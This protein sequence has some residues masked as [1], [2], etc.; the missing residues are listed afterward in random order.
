MIFNV[1]W[2]GCHRTNTCRNYIQGLIPIKYQRDL[3]LIT[4]AEKSDSGIKYRTYQ[5]GADGQQKLIR[6]DE[7]GNRLEVMAVNNGMIYGELDLDG[8]T[9]FKMATISLEDYLAGKTNWKL[10]EY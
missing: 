10:L 6:E 4:E 1:G 5:Y 2:K 7:E 9:V 8:E 3:K